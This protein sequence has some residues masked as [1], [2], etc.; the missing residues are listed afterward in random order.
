MT[1]H[2][3]YSFKKKD[4]EG[5]LHP[6]RGCSLLRVEY[7]DDVRRFFW[8]YNKDVADNFVK[9]VNS[10]KIEAHEMIMPTKSRFF[11]DI[12]LEID[13]DN[14]E[15]LIQQL[16]NE[17][18]SND[19]YQL[20]IL[21][22]KLIDIYATAIKYSLEEHSIDSNEIGFD[23]CAT[24]RN[25]KNKISIHLITNMILSH[26]ENKALAADI[27]EMLSIYKDNLD[28]DDYCSDLLA[29]AVDSK[30]YRK[31]GSLAL[32]YGWKKGAQTIISKQWA[33][34]NQSYWL[35]RSDEWIA[36]VDD[37]IHTNYD[38]KT[39]S[40]YSNQ[41]ASND[42]ITAAL[43]HVSNIP[44]Y[45][46]MYFDIKNL[47]GEGCFR[48]PS[49]I[50]PSHCSVCDKKHERDHN[51]LLIFNE[52]K[53]FATWKCNRSPESKAKRFY[54]VPK[55]IKVSDA[56]LEEFISKTD[57]TTQS[58]LADDVNKAI[59]LVEASKKGLKQKEKKVIDEE[60][61]Q[62]KNRVYR[63][64][65]EQ[66]DI[67]PDDLFKTKLMP[68]DEFLITRYW[69]SPEAFATGFRMCHAFL[70]NKG[71]PKYLVKSI[72]YSKYESGDIVKSVCYKEYGLHEQK[73][74]MKC[75]MFNIKDTKENKWVRIS[76]YNIYTMIWQS[77]STYACAKFIPHS[78]FEKP[79]SRNDDGSR[80]L[81]TFGG[82]LH[83]YDPNFEID[84]ELV[85]VWLFHGREVI[86]D[87]DLDY[88][89]YLM[90][91]FAH[92]IQK[93]NVK[94]ATVPMIKSDQRAGK[95]QYFMVFICYTVNPDLCLMTG[96]MDDIVGNF[97]S[98]SQDKLLI[99]LDEAVDAKDKSGVSRFKH[100][101]A[102]GKQTINEKYKAQKT[103]QS[104]SNYACLT[105]HDFDTM[106]EKDQGRIFPKVASSKYC[107][108]TEYWKNYRSKLLNLNAGK[109]IFHWL[110]RRDIS[111]FNVR[112][113]PRG[114]YEKELAKAQVNSC[115]K[116][117]LDVRQEMFAAA[118]NLTK[119]WT[120]DEC[121]DKYK[122]WA[123]NNLNSKAGILSKLSFGKIMNEYKIPFKQLRKV[124]DD[125]ERAK[126]I[127]KGATLPKDKDKQCSIRYREMSFN[128]LNECLSSVLTKD[129]KN[130]QIEE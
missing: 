115:V 36:S 3:T 106:I 47:R 83:D 118:D 85:D 17:D 71:N 50:A 78:P 54:F 38:I 20:D 95:G 94:T 57:S 62:A 16:L 126:W 12:D 128:V 116:W 39:V 105:N 77:K 100:M 40:E 125:E 63:I 9:Y 23:Y 15:T 111:N 4:G 60:E 48:R 122:D 65:G 88:F 27:K 14:K 5:Y 64:I 34:P 10:L 11:L 73:D 102:E 7:G 58:Q 86:S 91:W 113:I 130:Q 28:L 69:D 49:R 123:P 43:Q 89:E 81:N 107:Y 56:D 98:L 52:E 70:T 68:I 46:P 30:Q 8:I 18:L 37:V 112:Q 109:H 21:S 129:E 75:A 108:D 19:L 26:S 61:E 13:N 120:S 42:F 124:L 104:F 119:Q 1:F 117:M 110:C 22:T 44:I 32:P 53:G 96:N 114:D 101:T 2:S 97:N 80:V 103:I 35:T 90:D 45:D 82:W 99:V 87:G 31:H 33:I 74:S 59:E 121:Y 66:I 76:L 93:P 25:R 127:M 55:E 24:T 41:N 67:L 84:Q 72:E 29:N 79:K 51:L 92:I 6:I